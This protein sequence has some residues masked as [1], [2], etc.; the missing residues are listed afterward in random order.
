MRPPEEAASTADPFQ[1]PHFVLSHDMDLLCARIAQRRAEDPDRRV[2]IGLVGEP[3]AGKST[4]AAELVT[5]LQGG[6]VLVPMDGFHLS[7]QVLERLGRRNRKGA[8]DTFDA[9]GFVHLLWRLRHQEDI[10]YAPEFLRELDEPIAGAIA[11]QKFTPVVIVEGNYLLLNEHPWHKVRHH[12]D[13]AWYVDLDRAA[14]LHRL[15][16]RHQSFGLTPT[17]A[18]NWATTQ[19]EANA[20]RIRATRQRA[21][22]I[23][24]MP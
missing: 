22:L 15:A 2:I 21:D 20:K 23:I 11:V 14:R 19:D 24:T 17:D 8:P 6:A 7:N 16:E 13:T 18:K 1:R 10:V 3:G 9:P 12:L 5:A 4:L